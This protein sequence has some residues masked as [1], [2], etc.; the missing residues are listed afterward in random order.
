[1]KTRTVVLATLACAFVLS[2]AAPAFA[3]RDEWRHHEWREHEWRDHER[4]EH[5]HWRSTYYAPPPTYYAPPSTY[6]APPPAY[7]APPAY[8]Y[9]PPVVSFGF[10]FR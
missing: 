5:H 1:V 3:D 6:Y 10:G 8:Y 9:A 2:A 7:Y 4:R